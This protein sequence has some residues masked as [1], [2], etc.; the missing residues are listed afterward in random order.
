MTIP[1]PAVSHQYRQQ[2]PEQLLNSNNNL[3][4]P[5]NLPDPEPYSSPQYTTQRFDYSRDQT[6]YPLT[7]SQV[8]QLLRT[9]SLSPSTSPQVTDP[10]LHVLSDDQREPNIIF[11]KAEPPPNPGISFFNDQFNSASTDSGQTTSEPSDPSP[12]DNGQGFYRDH[13]D[14][15]I[16]E[17]LP[18]SSLKPKKK[19]K[20][21]L[22]LYQDQTD[23]PV[24]TQ[25][26]FRRK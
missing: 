20:K 9:T 24:Y 14:G 13:R 2:P 1:V 11:E 5:Q 26:Q 25:P 12:E 4:S 22:M 17:E 23:A 21:D 7:N 18:S 16:F 19:P 8:M 15:I 10:N 6:N 3:E